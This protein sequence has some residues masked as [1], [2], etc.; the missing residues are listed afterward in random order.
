VD[1]E[2]TNI[3]ALV[4]RHAGDP[5]GDRAVLVSALARLLLPHARG[6]GRITEAELLERA[7]SRA[8]R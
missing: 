4:R 6:R 3:A 1:L 2:L 8:G 5:R 7:A